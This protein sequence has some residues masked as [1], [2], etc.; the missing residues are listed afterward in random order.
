MNKSTIKRN[1]FN[2]L[3]IN[4]LQKKWGVTKHYIRMA[5]RGDRTSETCEEIVKDYKR[6]VKEVEN[7]LNK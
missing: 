1:K 4:R 3:V 6:L 2:E 7:A 5:L